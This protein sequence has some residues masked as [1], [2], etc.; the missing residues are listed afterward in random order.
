MFGNLRAELARNGIGQQEICEVLGCTPKTFRNKLNGLN[1]FK[2]SEIEKI[3][4][5][6]PE[7][8]PF[9]YLFDR[10]T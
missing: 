5:Y 4:M 7:K 10:N 6:M 8:L 2:L 1:E 3:Q 9:E